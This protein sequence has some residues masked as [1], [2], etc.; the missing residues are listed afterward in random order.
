VLIGPPAQ[1]G[2]RAQSAQ[3]GLENLA[4]TLSVEWARYGVSAVMMA[5]GV[6]ATETDLSTL[7]AFLVSEA[8]EYLSGCRLELGC[9]G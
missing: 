6:G 9:P 5:P 3:A 4:R 2:P 1:A 7:V 8:G